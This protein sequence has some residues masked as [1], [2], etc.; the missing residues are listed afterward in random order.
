MH[1]RSLAGMY[2]FKYLMWCHCMFQAVTKFIFAGSIKLTLLVLKYLMKLSFL[3]C[4]KMQNSWLPKK[5]FFILIIPQ[6]SLIVN[7]RKAWKNLQNFLLLLIHYTPRSAWW[8]SKSI[9]IIK[10]SL[11]LGRD[12]YQRLTY[13]KQKRSCLVD[14]L[15]LTWYCLL[16]LHTFIAFPH[17]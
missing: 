11:G 1:K 14:T 4:D 9:K 16:C 5:Q 17:E 3:F 10:L 6:N 2:Q 7:I 8:T 13:K 15:R 12:N